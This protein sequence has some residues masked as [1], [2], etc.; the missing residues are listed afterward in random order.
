MVV[1]SYG[2]N[3]Y[4]GAVKGSEVPLGSMLGALGLVEHMLVTICGAEIWR[5]IQL[6]LTHRLTEWNMTCQEKKTR[7]LKPLVQRQKNHGYE[8]SLKHTCTHTHIK[9]LPWVRKEGTGGIW[10]TQSGK[11]EV[12]KNHN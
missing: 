9:T 11:Q 8:I 2:C 7:F 12:K 6:V 1:R 10:A 3:L 4:T 5:R